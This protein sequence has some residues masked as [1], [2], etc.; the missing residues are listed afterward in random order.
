VQELFGG[1]GPVV[2]DGY[3]E[4]PTRPG[5]GVTLDEKIA[6]AH[7]YKPASRPEYKFGDGSVT[8]Q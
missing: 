2:K 8:D 5:L 6:A 1:A 7:P 3:A 4:L